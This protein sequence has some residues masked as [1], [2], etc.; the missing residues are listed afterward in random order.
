MIF[1]LTIKFKIATFGN[2]FSV[3]DASGQVLLYVKQK[4]FK[5]KEDV[6]IYRDESRSELLF[7]LK[8]N[9]IIDFSPT[10]QL[11]DAA[12][13]PTAHIKRNGGKSLWKADYDLFIGEQLVGKVQEENPWIKLF[14]AILGQIGLIGLV[15]GYFLNPTYLVTALDGALIGRIKKQPSFFES[16]FS[17][18]AESLATQSESTQQYYALLF[19][20]VVLLERA[21]G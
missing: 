14:D 3:T 15:T 6:A 16:S 5:L 9:K 7:S 11:T 1:P 20:V 21:R 8:A 10:F 17:I 12:G 4:M 13:N 2:R 18:E 19:M